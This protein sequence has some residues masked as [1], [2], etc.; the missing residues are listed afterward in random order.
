MKKKFRAWYKGDIALSSPLV[1]EVKEVDSELIWVCVSDPEITYAFYV[2]FI[3][4]DWIVEQYTNVED[5]HK[6]NICEGDVVRLWNNHCYEIKY[7]GSA[8]MLYVSPQDN[9]Q[10]W[11][12]NEE[13]YEVVGNIHE[14]PEL[15]THKGDD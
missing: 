9:A 11:H 3:D 13:H 2:P 4:D 12:G 15:L 7:F 1:F 5:K 8:F 6:V 14:N 10:L